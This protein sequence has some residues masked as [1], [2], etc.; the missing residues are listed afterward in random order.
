[1]EYKPLPIGVDDFAKLIEQGYFYIDKT[2]MIKELLDLKG[3]VH[4]F[5]R[6]RRFGKSLN[7]SMLRYFF[8]I[9]ID[10]NTKDL[11]KGL[12]IND[13]GE[14]YLKFQ[15]QFPTIHMSL[16]SGKQTTFSSSCF[17]ITEE[18]RGEF[19]RHRYVCGKLPEDKKQ[20]F[21]SILNRS[22]KKDV[23]T[24]ALKF[25]SECL[26]YYHNK[27]VIILI[28]E[29]DV[30]L[31]NAYFGGFYDEMIDFIRSLFE[32]GL[33]SNPFLHFAVITGCLR[34]SKESIFTGLNNMK[35]ISVTS[36]QYAEHFGFTQNEVKNMFHYYNQDTNLPIVK[37]WYDGYLFG[38]TEVYNPW[39]VINYMDSLCASPTEL[40]KPYWA[41]T[42]SNSIIRMLV[43]Q[44]ELPVRQEIESLIEGETIVKPIYEDI[45]Y[46][47]IDKSEDNLW[48][49]LFFTG[50]LKKVNE[51]MEGEQRYIRMAIPNAEVRY[52]YK[53]MIL[54]WFDTEIRKK[55]L[56]ALY[57][58][59]IEEDTHKMETLIS[60]QLLDAISY[61]DYNESFYHGF[62]A[63]LLRNMKK[64][65]VISNQESGNGR[66]DII[67]KYPSVKGHAFIL[68]FKVTTE[69]KNLELSCDTAL[70]QTKEQ[71][72]EAGLLKEGYQNIIKYGI[73]F[74]KKECMVKKL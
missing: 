69:Y 49:F 41:N 3:D 68:E 65:I 36:V 9:S 45:T 53:R 32:S 23:W 71:N 44:S 48:N 33:K 28:D 27:E 39:S 11:F 57:T 64:Y 4:L 67:I 17:K 37:E 22:A 60:E 35:I 42:S 51:S 73:G 66:P 8:E 14:D 55:D 21:E 61:Y 24:G 18:L 20:M 13:A 46:G 58:A 2:W 72:Y 59:I 12:K 7:L 74:Y 29:Y 15:G 16:K 40:P 30:P 6:P 54:S 70:Q 5:T 52:I 26:R 56:S 38:N 31:E 62:M 10:K 19:D 63:G 43:E 25:L 47:D 34:I 1:M 50:Y